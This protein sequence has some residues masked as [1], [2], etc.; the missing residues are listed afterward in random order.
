[1]RVVSLRD[2]GVVRRGRWILDNISWDVHAGEHWVVLG[3]NGAGKSTLVA[4]AG[5]RL[6]PSRGE[7]TV[8]GH[9]MGAVH[10][11]EIIPSIGFV[12]AA[13]DEVIPADERVLDVVATSVHGMRGRWREVYDEVD[14]ARAGR[15]LTSWGVGDL[16][17]RALGTLSDGEWKRVM[18]ARALM[19][20][21]EILILDEPAAGLDVAARERVVADLE[22]MAVGGRGPTTITVTHHFEEIPSTASHAIVLCTGRALAQGPIREVITD[23]AVSAAYGMTLRVIAHEGRWTVVRG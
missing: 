22:T 10:L 19:T 23:D 5:A 18:I 17:E 15:M 7:V 11:S 8:V 4:I 9:D 6:F 16:T 21:P 13:D 14:I 3:P 2:V 20:D 1:M 12:G